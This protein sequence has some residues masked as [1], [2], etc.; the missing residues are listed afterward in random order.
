[1]NRKSLLGAAVLSLLAA[2]TAFAAAPDPGPTFSKDVA[3]LFFSKCAT[4]HR[5]G[6]IAPMSLL[7]Y[8]D[9]RPW[10]KSIA[11]AVRSREMPPWGASPEHGAWAND[12]SLSPTAI[13]TIVRWVQSG[14][15][16]GD[17]ADLPPLPVFPKGWILGEPDYI[18]ELDEVVVAAGGDDI[19]P[20]EWVD[21]SDLG[22]EKWVKA[23]QFLPGDRRVTH[24]I[25]ATYNTGAAGADGRGEFQTERGNGGSGIF[26]VWTAGMQPYVFP[27]GMGRLISSQTK[28]LVDRHYH[29]FGEAT[30]DRT[31]IGLYFGEGELQKE[32]ATMAVVNTGLRI[33]PHDPNYEIV[34]FHVFDTDMEILAFSPHLHVRGKAMRYDVTYPDGTQET[35]LDVP[36]YNY[37]WQWLYYPAEPI[38]LPAGTRLDVTAA[39]DNSA[40]NLANPDPSAEIIYRGN[41][42]NE[43][44]VGFFEAIQSDGVYHQPSDPMA[45]LTQ[46]LSEH[47][48]EDSYLLS[49]FLPL[50]L[51]VPK[52][53]NGW[54][55]AVQGN[56]M[57]TVTLDDIRWQGDKLLIRTQFPTAEASAITTIIEAELNDKGQLK[58]TLTYGDE[59]ETGDK[60]IVLPI[61]GKPQVAS[62][63]EATAG[64][65]GP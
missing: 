20:K 29:P 27:A 33:P 45:K 19:F 43:M 21:L 38:H 26:G 62:A 48:A 39:W 52:S 14:A 61:L 63:A 37:N 7:T 36:N 44:F 46:L 16:E 30:T 9:A 3:P 50:G 56:G 5:P 2:N 64:S 4:C 51:Y 34:G 1:M 60:P 53:G 12:M 10:A 40:D 11:R 28:V 25:L 8:R 18:I 32:V 59:A 57:T 13:E 42:F 6:E 65:A 58:G 15:L 31:R 23:I 55:Y 47:P 22:G 54:A 35:L 24:H 49:G 17:P 41:T